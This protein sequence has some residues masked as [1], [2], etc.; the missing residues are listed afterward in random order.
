[1]ETK[2]QPLDQG[3]ITNLKHHYSKRTVRKMLDRI[4]DGKIFD[5]TLLDCVME[6]DKAWHEVF[7]GTISNCFKK[8]G[9]R[10]DEGF[11]EH[12]EED[13]D[14]PLSDL[15]WC[16]FKERVNF[17]AT[18]NEY[19]DVDCEVIAAEY[20]TDTEIIQTT[21]MGADIDCEVLEDDIGEDDCSETLPSVGV[22]DA[23]SALETVKSYIVAQQNVNYKFC[24]CIHGLQN[25]C[26]LR[27]RNCKK[28]VRIKDFRR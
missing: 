25:V 20:P 23:I 19:V 3:V 1:M 26:Y 8:V 14:I 16:K 6:L 22:R 13:A 17:E 27:K 21:K 28:Q 10:K 4:D 5:I 7:S 12:R 24:Y 18:F 9:M 2:L 15:E 11:R